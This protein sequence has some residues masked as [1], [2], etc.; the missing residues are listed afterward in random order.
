MIHYYNDIKCINCGRIT[1][2]RNIFNKCPEC[3]KKGYAVNY[4]VEYDYNKLER[5]IN[6][7]ISGK[8]IWKYKSFFA[9]KGEIEPVTLMEGDT[10]LIH[11]KKLGEYLDLK[12]LYIK[13]E[14]RNPTWSYKDRL[15][16]VAITRAKQDGAKVITISST[17]NHGAS[18][19]AYA[20]AADIPC[21]IFTVPTVP[22][23]MKTLMQS[24]GAY[25]IAV[26]K[27]ENR[28][29][30]MQKCVKEFGWTPISGYVSP[31]IGSNPYG[32]DGYKSLSFEIY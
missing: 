25:V 31:P 9:I 4:S 23:T 14:T 24:Y 12:N 7:P 22:E 15:C 5:D 18:A 13:D 17:G 11:V 2:E 8:G 6:W 3:T 27:P 20:A 26:P 21:V 29:E 16:S 30:I 1:D 28:W 32:I 10:P 19:A